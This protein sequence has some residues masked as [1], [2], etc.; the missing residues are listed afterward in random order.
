MI[1]KLHKPQVSEMEDIPHD[2]VELQKK[3]NSLKLLFDKANREGTISSISQK[4]HFVIKDD[5]LYL[6]GQEG[7]RLVVPEPMRVKILQLGH[8]IPWAGHLG[9][10]KTFE[11]I[12]ARF[13]WPRLYTDVIDFCKSCSE[14]QLVRPGRRGDRAPLVNL[15]IIDIPFERIAMDIVGPLD[16]SKSGNRY[17]LVVS[18]YATRYPEAFPLRNIKTRQVG[19]ALVQLFSRVG[20][21]REIITDQGSNFTSRQMKQIYSMLHI[22]RIQ[23]TPYHPQTDGLVE[24]LNQ[25]LKSMLRK[26]V[27]ESGKDWDQWLPYLLFAYREVPQTST[28]FSPF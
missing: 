9:Q 21:P 2:I 4:D 7:E 10:H 14:C 17:I 13:Y 1:E 25:T 15:P 11:K 22:H 19:N 26:F 8:S 16:R 3:D 6:Q 5:R 24:R 28:G 18:D 27:C 20:F 12:A 23:T